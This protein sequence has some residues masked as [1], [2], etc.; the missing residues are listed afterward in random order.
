MTFEKAM[1]V[2]RKKQNKVFAMGGEKKIR[3]QHDRG[4]Y[5]AR[6]R[7]DLLFDDDS[8]FEVGRFA[9]SDMRGM[10]EKTP[11]FFSMIFRDFL[12]ERKRRGTEW[13]QGL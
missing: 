1:N 5:T 6:E 4:R 3:L 11:F 8:F 10:E 13:L 7:I 9:H 2:L 12:W